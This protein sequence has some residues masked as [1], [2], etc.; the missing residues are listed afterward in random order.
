MYLQKIALHNFRSF[1]QAVYSLHPH[2]TIVTGDNARGKTNL[3]EAVYALL[4]GSGFREGKEIEHINY[5]V[6]NAN[7]ASVEGLYGGGEADEQTLSAKLTFQLANGLVRKTYMIDKS[8]KA[9]RTYLQHNPKAVLFAPEQIEMLTGSPSRRRSYLD[10][11][12]GSYDVEYKKRLANYEQA[13]R[14]R[15]K[16]LEK[17][18]DELKLEQELLFWDGYLVDQAHYVTKARTDYI[19]FICEQPNLEQKLFRADYAPNIFSHERL[20]Q[21]SERER[22]ARRT[23]IG[24]QKDDFTISMLNPP[25]KQ[26]KQI[27]L[28]G[29]RSEQRLAMIWLKCAEMRYATTQSEQKPIVLLDDVFSEFDEDNERLVMRIIANHQIIATTTESVAHLPDIVSGEYEVITL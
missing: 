18:Q 16:L 17:E 22:F 11:L 25:Q 21:T 1:N 29:S 9:L 20:A 14:K 3:L 13:L 2:M 4:V 27:D 19:S 8:K 28:Y 15:N 24:P 6:E 10:L 5:T 7:I 26:Y 12:L 23:L